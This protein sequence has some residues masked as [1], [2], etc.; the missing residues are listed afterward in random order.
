M[1]KK[2][3]LSNFREVSNND[4]YDGENSRELSVHTG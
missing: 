4:I 3:K 1:K 2:K